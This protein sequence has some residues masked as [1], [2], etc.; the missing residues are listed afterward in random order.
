MTKKRILTF[1]AGM[2]CGLLHAGDW[3]QFQRDAARTG[4][5]PDSPQPPYV[6]E[7]SVVFSPEP[8]GILQPIVYGDILYIPTMQGRLYGIN[9]ETGARLT[10]TEGLGTV[11]RSAAAADGLVYVCNLEGEVCAVRA[12]L[13]GGTEWRSDLGFPV[14]APVLAYE[15]KIY[16]GTRRGEFF[17]LDGKSGLELWRQKLDGYVWAP[18]SAADGR[19][20]AVTTGKIHVYALDAGSGKILWQSGRLPG[21]FSRNW[22]PVVTPER[23]GAG[24]GRVFVR[25]MPGEYRFFVPKPYCV[26][27]TERTREEWDKY[28]PELRAGKLPEDFKTAN[29]TL[30]KRLGED[31]L[32]QTMFAFDAETGASPFVVGAFHIFGGWLETL[33]P[34]AVDSEGMLHVPVPYQSRFGRLDPATGMIADILVGPVTDE[35]GINPDEIGTNSDECHASTCGGDLVFWLHFG[36]GNCDGGLAY[37]VKTR[38][39]YRVPMNPNYFTDRAVNISV[40]SPLKD[41]PVKQRVGY[42]GPRVWDVQQGGGYPGAAIWKNFYL[43]FATKMT[44]EMLY[45]IR[46]AGT[47]EK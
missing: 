47:Q 29:D 21:L 24:A 7:W 3:P 36:P 44:G 11:T 37:N 28:Y 16:V 22:P 4:W 33:P 12:G 15:G 13:E 8:M 39:I 43:K 25:T 19:V 18:A 23:S 6:L 31:I 5:S 40:A 2:A 30:V 42:P 41:Q 45:G 1:L 38:E 34:P 10:V 35:K 26:W 20:F 46:G 32:L 27:A 9:P 17:C 14:G